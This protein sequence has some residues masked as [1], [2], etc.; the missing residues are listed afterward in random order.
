[1]KTLLMLIEIVAWIVGLVAVVSLIQILWAVA[2]VLWD[3][4]CTWC[5]RHLLLRGDHYCRRCR[6]MFNRVG[7]RS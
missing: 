1:M 2:R 3:R 5:K 6:G 7:G 4:R